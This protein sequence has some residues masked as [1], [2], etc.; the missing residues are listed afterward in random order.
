ML[1]SFCEENTTQP[2]ECFKHISSLLDTMADARRENLAF[3]KQQEEEE[4]KALKE[5]Q[6][7]L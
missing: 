7:K 6:V 4:S 5:A 3:K 1:E 2:D